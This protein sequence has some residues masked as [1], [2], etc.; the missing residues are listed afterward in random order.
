MKVLFPT[1]RSE[2]VMGIPLL[3]DEEALPS[4]GAGVDDNALTK[5]MAIAAMKDRLYIPLRQNQEE[6]DSA[7]SSPP[8]R[9]MML[10]ILIGI[11]QQSKAHLHTNNWPYDTNNDCVENLNQLP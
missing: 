1:V 8:R 7:L 2:V 9:F 3:L 5:R 10:L 6:Y 11:N 4:C